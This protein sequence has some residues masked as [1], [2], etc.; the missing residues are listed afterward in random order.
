M[1]KYTKYDYTSNN[2][3]DLEKFDDEQFHI[4]SLKVPYFSKEDLTITFKN[5]KIFVEGEKEV[6]N[7]TLTIDN[8][9]NVHPDYSAEDIIV[10][11]DS[12]VLFFKFPRIFN[13]KSSKQI[14][15]M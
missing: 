7:H 1:F 8:N 10:E 9:F 5:G 14:K 2:T 4:Y 13:K 3:L 12:G 11:Y 6:Y 15:I